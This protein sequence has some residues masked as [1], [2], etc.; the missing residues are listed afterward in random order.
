MQV[1]DCLVEHSA[2]LVSQELTALS[3]QAAAYTARNLLQA[4]NKGLQS[5][6]SD[7]NDATQDQLVCTPTARARCN[8]C[9]THQ[10]CLMMY[11]CQLFS[12]QAGPSTALWLA[13][14]LVGKVTLRRLGEF[15]MVHLIMHIAAATGKI[16][17]CNR[18]RQLLIFQMAVHRTAYVIADR[19]ERGAAGGKCDTY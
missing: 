7:R 6:P 14:Q 3:P 9:L 8:D 17:I 5:L 10:W 16:G 1:L 4:A 13:F 2:D 19:V 18:T 12:L 15:C 11:H